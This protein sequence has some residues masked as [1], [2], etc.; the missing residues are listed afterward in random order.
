[1]NTGQMLEQLGPEATEEMVHAEYDG[2]SL[3]EIV[4][5]INEMFPQETDNE[6]LAEAVY[7]FCNYQ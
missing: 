2:K 3:A 4:A 5:S 7:E 6:I 1:M